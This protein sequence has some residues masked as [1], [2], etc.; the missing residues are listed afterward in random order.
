MTFR[1]ISHMGAED[2]TCQVNELY[3]EL[4]KRIFEDK[5]ADEELYLQYSDLFFR[6]TQALEARQS[7]AA[8]DSSGSATP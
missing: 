1:D 5:K 2:L 6:I 7:S 4:G 3:C 8:D